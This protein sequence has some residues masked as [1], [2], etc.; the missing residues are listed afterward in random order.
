MSLAFRL[1]LGIKLG[2][3]C[4]HSKHLAAGAISPAP[5]FPS[6]MWPSLSMAVGK[7][8]LDFDSWPWAH[9]CSVGL[10]YTSRCCHEQLTQ[11]CRTLDLCT[12]CFAVLE[13]DYLLGKDSVSKYKLSRNVLGKSTEWYVSPALL[14]NWFSLLSLCHYCW[15]SYLFF[16]VTET[17][18][19]GANLSSVWKKTFL[20][21]LPLRWSNTLKSVYL[22]LY[23][24]EK[25]N[26]TGIKVQKKKTYKPIKLIL[27]CYSNILISSKMV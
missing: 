11:N 2:S 5:G 3:S 20:V 27:P 9:A 7:A 17:G 23:L 25:W 8:G 16:A 12:S 4:F 21:S 24:K 19:F 10:D 15:P 26:R 14:S 22:H 6:L 13:M 18:L 1:R